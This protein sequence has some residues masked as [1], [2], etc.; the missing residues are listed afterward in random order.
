ME[1]NF[2][3][4]LPSTGVDRDWRGTFWL[5]TSAQVFFTKKV[6]FF[7]AALTTLCFF[8]MS[9]FLF[10]EVFFSEWLLSF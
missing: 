3:E 4:R 10:L 8:V 7:M 6:D 1:L 5:K 9:Q 2:Q